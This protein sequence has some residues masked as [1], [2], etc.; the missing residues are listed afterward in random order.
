MPLL[1][2]QLSDGFRR[3]TPLSF[4][5]I[6]VHCTPNGSKALSPERTIDSL[7]V[8]VGIG[9]PVAECKTAIN[10]DCRACDIG[11]KAVRE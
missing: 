8:P 7:F 2:C 6:T 1:V 9:N 10:L 4:C 5:S 3:G 11:A